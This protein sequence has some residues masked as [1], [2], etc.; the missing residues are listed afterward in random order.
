MSDR[1]TGVT[2]ISILYTLGSVG[3]VFF[4]LGSLL[5]GYTFSIILISA[6]LAVII[7]S[8]GLWEGLTWAWYL[9]IAGYIINII[10]G[11]ASLFLQSPIGIVSILLNV[12]FI[13]YFLQKHVKKFFEV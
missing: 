1:P 9:S 4:G 7:I 12:A 5:F 11:I 10:I 13:F 3:S 2:I 6:A 8:Y